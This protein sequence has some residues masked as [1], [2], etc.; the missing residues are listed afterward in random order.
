MAEKINKIIKK[1]FNVSNSNLFATPQKGAIKAN[2]IELIKLIN[3]FFTNLLIERNKNKIVSA[4]NTA[5]K[6]LSL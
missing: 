2:I 4:P 6:R 5:E 3:S 1:Q